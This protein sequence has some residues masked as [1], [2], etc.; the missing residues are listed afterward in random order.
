MSHGLAWL[1]VMFM[2]FSELHTP[3]AMQESI[4]RGVIEVW[5]NLHPTGVDF[6]DTVSTSL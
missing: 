2:L 6:D 4:P 5:Q 3:S 1:I